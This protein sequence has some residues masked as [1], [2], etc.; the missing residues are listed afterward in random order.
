MSK[1]FCYVEALQGLDYCFI[2]SDAMGRTLFPVSSFPRIIYVP[3]YSYRAETL[4]RR[5][6][7][8][9]SKGQTN[10]ADEDII[11]KGVDS[12]SCVWWSRLGEAC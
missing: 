4:I 12:T 9:N 1:S 7:D 3:I 5:M 2:S 8:R 11:G 10:R 6:R